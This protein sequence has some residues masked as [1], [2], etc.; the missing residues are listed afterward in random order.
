MAEKHVRIATV[1]D[2]LTAR[3]AQL[4]GLSTLAHVDC[5]ARQ[6]VDS[7][8]RI[9]FISAVLTDQRIS[10][11]RL[12]PSA[13]EFDP[14]RAAVLELRRGRTSNAC[15]LVFLFVHFGKHPVD[16]YAGAASIYGGLGHHDWRWEALVA[17]PRAFRAWYEHNEPRL[18]AEASMRRFG[19]HRRYMSYKRS[20]T[21]DCIE[22]YVD[23]MKNGID[24]KTRQVINK[25]GQNPEDVFDEFYVESSN[26]K[27]FG[28]LAAFDY[29]TMLGKLG[30]IPAEPGHPY[31]RG[32]TG[33][34]RGANLLWTGNVDEAFPV[35]D[36]TAHA[37]RLA[38]DLQ[39]R[40]QVIE[41]ALCNWQKAP[42][43]Y[44]YFRG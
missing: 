1:R 28:R 8:R 34:K 24:L 9:K 13:A 10:L 6:I 12:D 26:V 14:I 19:S 21:L 22:S 2:A 39:L 41:D 33:P 38:A 30:L 4:P 43:N 23:W 11:R 42:D 7:E 20:H 17:D 16:G 35:A 27:H 25:V 36:A 5:L 3:L 18:L 15:W 32:A 44:A 37:V 40:H 31:F 29:T